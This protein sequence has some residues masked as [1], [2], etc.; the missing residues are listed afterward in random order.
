[1]TDE[2]KHVEANVAA[3][4]SESDDQKDRDGALERRL[5]W[6]TDL[7]LMPALGM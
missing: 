6:K 3:L 5:V 4:G 2:E 1:M 7:I